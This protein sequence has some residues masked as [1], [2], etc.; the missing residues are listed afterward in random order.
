MSFSETWLNPAVTNDDISLL[1]YHLPK[2]KDRVADSHG[3]VVIY[4]KDHIHYVRRRDLEPIGVECVWVELRLK[5]KHILFGLFYRPPNSDAL[6]FSSI[7]DSI[8]LAV[9][10]GIQDIIVTGDLNS[11]ML[12]LQTSSKIKSV[13]EQFSFTHTINSPTHFTEHSSPLIDILLTNNENQLLYTEIGDHFLNQE[14]RYHCPIFGILNFT[15]P[16]RKSHLR[17]T[18]SYDQGD[19]NLLREKA[20][21][22]NWERIHDQYVIKHVQNITE[23]II[24][25]SKACT[26]NRL[27]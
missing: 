16:E 7:E 12:N 5:H 23:H 6:Y 14:V 10:T 24:D 15:K 27:T 26:P 11:K 20:S 1:S 18:W 19:H 17:H 4:I 3:G 25:M 13:C 22:T 8:H 9:D 2:L 21:R